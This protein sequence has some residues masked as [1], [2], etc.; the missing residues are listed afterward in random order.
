SSN[1]L[2][3]H[4]DSFLGPL[5]F[6]ELVL[7]DGVFVANGDFGASRNRAD[8]LSALLGEQ[9]N[10]WSVNPKF[11]LAPHTS[12]P[13]ERSDPYKKNSSESESRRARNLLMPRSSLRN[14]IGELSEYRIYNAP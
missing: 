4:P 12:G 14:I 10:C 9:G 13:P 7:L 3:K 8:Y 6:Y 5:H 1:V 2:R 11:D